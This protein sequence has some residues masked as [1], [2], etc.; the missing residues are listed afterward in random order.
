M[1]FS[2]SEK[3]KV[4]LEMVREFM[5]KEVFPLEPH[6]VD[7]PFKAMWPEIN[8]CREMVKKMELWA[9]QVPTELGGMGL[10]LVEHALMTE[11]LGASPL[12]YLIFGCQAP[13]AGN[14]EI[15]EKYA[16]PEIREQYLMPLVRGEIRSCFSMCE[17]EVAG[18]NPT[19]L[20]STAVLDG[21]EWV[22]NGHKWFSSAADGA[23]FSIVMAVSDP[24]A[25]VYQRASM[26]I[27]PTDNPGFDLIRNISVMGH[28]GDDYHSHGEIMYRNCRVPAGNLLGP[29][30]QGFVIAQERLGPGR[31]HHCM[32]WIGICNRSFQIMC[33]RAATRQVGHGKTLGE[34][35][36]VQ[37]WIAQ[38][39]A[40]ILAARLMVLNA[41]WKIENEGVYA[42]REEI[43]LIKFYV[44]PIMLRVVDRAIQVHGGM[45]VSDDTILSFFYRSE[46]AARI[47][48]G[49]DEVHKIVCSRRI[50]REHQP[51]T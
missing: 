35:Q 50:L 1:D 6:F 16:T 18:S 9:P 51:A 42:A 17:P 27:V 37:E 21:D 4:I 22:I 31:I 32:R 47:Y 26:I 48:D 43:S 7:K 41:A 40:E 34:K 46:R 29:R 25:D 20:N 45:G 33:D 30:G 39:R 2:V 11:E 8:R 38:S 19:L 28:A 49:P 24:D 12:G 5:E 14:I 10:G 3:M 36:I 13:D 23:A 44:A 15:L